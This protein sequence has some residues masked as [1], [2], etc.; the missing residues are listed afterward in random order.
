MR[1]LDRSARDL[2]RLV[3]AASSLSCAYRSAVKPA[4]AWPRVRLTT[5]ARRFTAVGKIRPRH[6]Y[7][8][9]VHR[10][11]ESAFGR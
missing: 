7:N 10:R 8:P 9:D 11:G 3:V 5:S 2:G 4:L 1:P 6:P